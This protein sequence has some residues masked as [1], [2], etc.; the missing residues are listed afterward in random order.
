MGPGNAIIG[1]PAKCHLNCVSLECRFGQTLNASCVALRFTRGSGSVLLTN[2]IFLCFSVGGDG[3][4]GPPVPPLDPLMITKQERTDS[5]YYKIKQGLNID[6][7][8]T[9]LVSGQHY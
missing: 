3:V 9:V 6:L 5:E 2:A 1:R 4:S 8:S 7:R